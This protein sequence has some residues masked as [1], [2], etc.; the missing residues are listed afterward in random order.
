[1]VRVMWLESALVTDANENKHLHKNLQRKSKLIL[2]CFHKNEQR[3][4]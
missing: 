3:K 1:M 4:Q 2:L